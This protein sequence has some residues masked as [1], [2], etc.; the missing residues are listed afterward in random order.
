MYGDRFHDRGRVYEGPSFGDWPHLAQVKL[1]YDG[2][3]RLPVRLPLQSTGTRS[4]RKSAHRIRLISLANNEGRLLWETEPVGTGERAVTAFF[5]Y[6]GSRGRAEL[7]VEGEPALSF[8]LG[9]DEAFEIET[10]PY[11]LC[12]R[13]EAPRA[14]MPYGG[15]VLTMDAG[16]EGPI[17]L[18]AKFMSGMSVEPMFVSL[19]MR[20][21]QAKALADLAARCDVGQKR[22]VVGVGRITEAETNSYPKDTGRWFVAEVF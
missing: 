4:D 22:R 13:A 8:P 7:L 2:D 5:A 16:R 9:S 15:Y 19:D 20:R 12:Y 14:G 6:T 21:T 3:Y 17:A 1:D 18:G 11:R 10:P